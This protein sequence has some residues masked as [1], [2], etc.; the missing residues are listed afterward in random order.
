MISN[1]DHNHESDGNKVQAAKVRHI[2]K[3]QS[4]TN[5]GRP[6]QIAA[7]V[8][9]QQPI[10]VRSAMGKLETVKRYIRRHKQGTL[11]KEPTS[12][13]NLE[14]VDEWTTTG[15]TDNEPF[16]IHDSSASASSRLIVF[17]T[18]QGLR[19]LS[20]ARSWY[21]DG[22]FATA[23][24]LFQQLY[25]IRVPIGQSAVTCVY[26]FMTD[27]SQS[28]YEQ[29]LR[30]IVDKC[31]ELGFNPDPTTVITD[32]EQAVI[33]AI[34]T[35][36]GPHVTHRGCFYHLTQSTWRKLQSL[37]L[38]ELY[39]TNDEVKHFCGML[40][41][42]AFLPEDQVAQGMAYLLDNTPPGL[43]P[44]VDYFNATYVT[45]TFRRIQPPSTEPAGDLP[46][47]RMRRI[48]PLYPP[49]LWNVHQATMNDEARTNNL[50]ESWNNGYQ[51]L[52]GYHHPS[53]WI[54]IESIRKD[55]AMAST[56][57]LQD[58]RGDPPRKRV[59]RATKDHQQRLKNLCTSV[60]DNT[61]TLDEFLKGVGHCIRLH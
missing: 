1:L 48:P 40:D 44:L 29:M 52:I 21:M 58:S 16:L 42:L 12:L 34:S 53:I 47:I 14:I 32:F 10:E 49:S 8:L 41:G 61:K 35:I 24:K 13:R 30:A 9:A 4:S 17:A 20:R 26:A 36:I 37:G 22:T 50:C 25:I 60:A 39:K 33:N 5:R 54:S 19:Q 15:F 27:K 55:Q 31:D 7:D 46:P 59:H 28:M 2:L 6:G 45:G 43:E 38:V 11:P 51:H 56:L 3:E 23:P 57:M 18:E